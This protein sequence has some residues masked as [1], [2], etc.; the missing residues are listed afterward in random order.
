MRALAFDAFGNFLP[1]I[2]VGNKRVSLTLNKDYGLAISLQNE[3][4]EF[5]GF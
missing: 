1:P 3:K 4:R 5:F 2:F